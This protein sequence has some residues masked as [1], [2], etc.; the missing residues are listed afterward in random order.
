MRVVKGPIA[1][2]ITRDYPNGC[3]K[4]AMMA[5]QSASW[6]SRDEIRIAGPERLRSINAAR[7]SVS[8][9]EQV[10]GPGRGQRLAADHLGEGLARLQVE[11]VAA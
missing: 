8:I 4:L 10:L 3:P 7:M 1:D 5:T 9:A 2:I 6:V 11:P